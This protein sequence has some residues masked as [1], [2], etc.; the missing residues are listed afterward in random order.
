MSLS[1]SSVYSHAGYIDQS[2][3]VKNFTDDA[4]KNSVN[5]KLKDHIPYI[6]YH[7]YSFSMT[8][9]KPIILD[10]SC[11]AC[12][13]VDNMD[14]GVDYSSKPYDDLIDELV[15]AYYVDGSKAELRAK[16][17]KYHDS[18]FGVR[19][20]SADRKY[21]VFCE[22]ILFRVHNNL[23]QAI[24]VY[25]HGRTYTIY[26]LDFKGDVY[27]GECKVKRYLGST[28]SA[29]EAWHIYATE[30]LAYMEAKKKNRFLAKKSQWIS[31]LVELN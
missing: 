27:G 7:G 15:E 16:L 5:G 12:T 18:K 6:Q 9:A 8:H 11:A 23:Y 10:D 25:K 22:D 2:W 14:C 28:E 17:I 31:E 3:F 30:M 29:E 26:I 24:R 19:L 1:L 20:S 4:V 21:V 13:Y